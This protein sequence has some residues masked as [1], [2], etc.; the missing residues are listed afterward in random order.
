VHARR[1]D[2]AANE[3]ARWAA[4]R[5]ARG[6]GMS[7]QYVFSVGDC[8]ATRKRVLLDAEDPATANWTRFLNHSSAKPN[9]T[10]FVEVLPPVSAS[11]GA[12]QLGTPVV[13]FVT[14]ETVPKGSELL[15]DYADGFDLDVLGF[16]E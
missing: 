16:E 11:D 6:V 4:E 10:V 2:E 7:G 15:F 3:Q 12:T 1:T 5:Q 9:L 8:P 13:R 14:S